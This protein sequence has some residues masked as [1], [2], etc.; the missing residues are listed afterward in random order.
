[1][2]PVLV[3]AAPPAARPRH[4]PVAAEALFLAGRELLKQGDW[5]NACARLGESQLLDAAAGTALNLA[6]CEDKQGHVASAWQRLR[7]A[8][9]LLPAADD[10]IPL[11]R[12]QLAALEQRLPHLTVR[13]AREAPPGTRVLR[14][15]VEVD[16]AVMGFAEPVDP[17]P[18]TLRVTAPGYPARLYTVDSH[19]A[20]SQE[21]LV[22]PGV[23][24]PTVR[25]RADGR[26]VAGWIAI[27]I[28]LPA[29]ALGAV[30]GLTVIDR[31]NER[32][33]LCPDN[34][35]ATPGALA[36]ARSVDSSGK[37]LSIVSTASFAVAAA[38]V[39]T[40]VYLLLTAHEKETGAVVTAGAAP[41]GA[42]LTLAGTF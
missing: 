18:H 21:L 35:C 36:N 26:R 20:V 29:A 16:A 22:E 23:A 4:D 10:R 6:V 32:R 17:G 31:G 13:L 33:S 3:L 28:G 30:T 9:D 11:A 14:D 5:A 8:L 38:G 12:R 19:E 2:L 41:G 7:E 37:A 40:G 24:A 25:T 1:M 27:G 42:A 39:A 15:G 34:A